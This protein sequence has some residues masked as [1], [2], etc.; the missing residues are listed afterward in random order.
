MH[1]WL[2]NI[3]QQFWYCRTNALFALREINFLNEGEILHIRDDSLTQQIHTSP[4]SSNSWFWSI[5]FALLAFKY[6][7]ITKIRWNQSHDI[8][9]LICKEIFYCFF[10]WTFCHQDYCAHDANHPMSSYDCHHCQINKKE[11]CMFH[12]LSFCLFK[13]KLLEI[14]KFFP[15]IVELHSVS[16]K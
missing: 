6:Q 2:W 9:F 11:V 1:K 10:T 12:F 4:L 13:S 15:K 5:S 7:N 14:D 16:S 3:C 8:G